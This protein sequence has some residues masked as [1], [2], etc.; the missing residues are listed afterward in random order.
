MEPSESI[1]GNRDHISDDDE[2]LPSRSIG[3]WRIPFMTQTSA[4][5]CGPT[6]LAMALGFYTQA[7]GQDEPLSSVMKQVSQTIYGEGTSKNGQDVRNNTAITSLRLALAAKK[8]MSANTSAS[9]SLKDVLFYST[10]LTLDPSNM[11]LPFYYNFADIQTLDE[12]NKLLEE[13]KS[14]G[15][16]LHERC[17][18]LSEILDFLRMQRVAIVLVDMNVIYSILE[19]RPYQGFTGHF[20][21]VSF[22]TPRRTHRRDA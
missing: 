14:A 20:L 19:G 13:A 17:I 6:A 1:G 10:S 16:I 4:M 18:S 3:P 12:S 21:V 9:F 11:E 2:H 22:F 15:I 8:I 7:E 5:D